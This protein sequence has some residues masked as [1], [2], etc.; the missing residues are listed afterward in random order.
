MR[1]G[2]LFEGQCLFS[3]LFSFVSWGAL[4]SVEYA[5]TLGN[6]LLVFLPPL[7][8]MDGVGNLL[9]DN[10]NGDGGVG[11]HGAGAVLFSE[12]GVLLDHVSAA[13]PIRGNW[14]INAA[15]GADNTMDYRVYIIRVEEE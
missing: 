6:V 8:L 1:G 13:S 9:V 7:I 4:W 10:R 15:D 5:V 3:C 11:R 2:Q 14:V 12:L